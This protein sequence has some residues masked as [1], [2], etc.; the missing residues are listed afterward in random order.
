MAVPLVNFALISAVFTILFT[1]P[2]VGRFSCPTEESQALLSFKEALNVSD[3]ILSSW[4]NGTDCCSKWDGISCNNFTYH[5]ERVNLSAEQGVQSGLIS[6]SLCN[7]PFLKYLIL[8]NI[9]LTGTIPSCLGN[10]SHLIYLHLKN[11]SLSG[12]V[13][14]FICQLT[15]LSHIDIAFNQFRGILPSC[16]QNL[17]LLKYL[18]ISFNQFNEK[19]QLAGLSSLEQLYARHFSFRENITSSEL[20]LPSSV[21]ILW[22]S[23]ISISD[24]LLHNLAELKF[25]FLSDCVLNISATWIPQFQLGGLDITS[26]S[27]GGR[28]P[29][30]LFTQYSLRGFQLVDDNIVG[31][32]PSWIWENFAELIHLNLSRNHLHGNLTIPN[33][34]VR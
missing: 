1:N 3:G 8:R 20:T 12:I 27:I 19:F 33:R 30:W 6:G 10:I 26:C 24:T 16:L 14:P 13:P 32:I 4:V 18:S 34:S 29:D 21:K 28:I 31:E 11:N 22:L 23:H 9:G 5:V 7:L 2:C 25:V 15:N 17:S